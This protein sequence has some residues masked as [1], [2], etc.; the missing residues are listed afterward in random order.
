MTW[1]D[2]TN[3]TPEDKRLFAQEQAILEVTELACKLMG[4]QGISDA[5]LAK[6]MGISKRRIVNMLDGRRNMTI[7]E[8]SDLLFHLNHR[9]ELKEK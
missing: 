9:F 7:R 4:E 5:G 6:K 8:V 1:V 3:K 2:E